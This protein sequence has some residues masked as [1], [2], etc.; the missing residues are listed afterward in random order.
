MGGETA[1]N[2]DLVFDNF[3]EY[4]AAEEQMRKH[5]AD[6]RSS[7]CCLCATM[8]RR[9]RHSPQAKWADLH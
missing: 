3:T 6:V 2:T 8:R 7:Q 1:V 9:F 5:Y 4:V